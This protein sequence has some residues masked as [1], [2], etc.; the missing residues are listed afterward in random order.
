MKKRSV[1]CTVPSIA[2][3]TNV[4]ALAANSDRSYFFVRNYTAGNIAVGLQGQALSAITPANGALVL[5]PDEW[6]EST[7]N[8]CPTGSITV[9]QASG[10]ATTLI[11]FIEG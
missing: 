8:T 1:K 10:S 5:K 7:D 9:Y 6:Y 4:V 3:A 11:L 2:N